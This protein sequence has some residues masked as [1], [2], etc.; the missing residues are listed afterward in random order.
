MHEEMRSLLN[1]C[2]DN[3]LH[4]TRLLELK[5]HLAS[6]Q[7]CREELKDLRLV[8]DLLQAA[9]APEFMPVGRFVSNLTLSLPRR[10]LRDRPLKPG[11]LAWWLVPAGL[12]AAF[13]FVRTVFVLS[14]VVTVADITGL[15]GSAAGW[16]DGGQQAIWFET[17]LNLTSGQMG[18]MQSTLAGLNNVSVLGVNLL[19]GFLWQAGII[20]CYWGW[21]AALW[22]RRG[23]QTMKR[24]ANPS[25]S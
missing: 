22:F 10:E 1:A 17:A 23:P 9:P 7:A 3:E 20:L 11:S 18:G 6:C 25:Q 15:L 5:V 8:S 21:L 24:T 19:N 16:L 14:N 2:L 4:G 13:F 12:L